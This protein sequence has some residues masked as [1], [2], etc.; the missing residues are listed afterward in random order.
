[1]IKLTLILIATLSPRPPQSTISTS[2]QISSISSSCPTVARTLHLLSR[3]QSVTRCCPACMQH[4]ATM[5]IYDPSFKPCT[6]EETA[7][8]TTSTP[9]DDRLMDDRTV[10]REVSRIE[11]TSQ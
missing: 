5:N 1:M 4:A 3:V 6:I 9:V 11:S 7:S 8:C 2:N 10:D